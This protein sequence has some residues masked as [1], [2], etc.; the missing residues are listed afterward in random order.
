MT[1]PIEDIIPLIPQKPPFVMVGTLVST[2]ENTTLSSFIISDDNIFVKDNVFQEAG[3]MENIAQTAALRAGYIAQKENKPVAVGYIGAVSHFEIF[4]LP[5][6]GDEI[7][8]MIASQNQIFDITVL[9]GRV[10][11]N[12]KLI[13]QCEM[14]VFSR[15]E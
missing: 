6:V 15:S 11:L 3:L 7:T 4:D 2:N 9:S 13:A 12:D 1:L 14:K 5:R 8:T 10:W